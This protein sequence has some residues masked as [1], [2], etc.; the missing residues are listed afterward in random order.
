MLVAIDLA[1]LALTSVASPGTTG[2]MPR[3]TRTP[4]PPRHGLRRLR[5]AK[6]M[7]RAELA[8]LTG[9]SASRIVKLERNEARL[10]VE[11]LAVF[12]RA[13]DCRPEDLVAAEGQV[14][15]PVFRAPIVDVSEL[16][17]LDRVAAQAPHGSV[18]LD[19]PVARAVAVPMLDNSMDRIAPL[20]SLLVLDRDDRQLVDGEV[21]LVRYDGRFFCRRW[22][23]QP[24]GLVP[25]SVESG[26]PELACDVQPQVI[27]RLIVVIRKV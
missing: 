5:E 27:G 12:A 8:G 3:R 10:K 17:D 2:P 4:I 22:R 24:P 21:Y 19:E 18:P 25:D 15:E 13:L 7:T 9:F 26:H 14:A 6:D 16:V 20:G 11:D 1:S 23:A